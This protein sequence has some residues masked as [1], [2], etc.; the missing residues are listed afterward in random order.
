M[1]ISTAVSDASQSACRGRSDA[2]GPFPEKLHRMLEY[3]DEEGLCDVVSW[4][5]DGRA[6]KIHD[7]DA[8]M[9][10]VAGHFFRATK[11]RSVHRQFLL[12]GF[13]R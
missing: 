7:A 3:A 2:T 10:R 9:S 5:L 1:P 4:L 6:F 13:T 11:L 8:F 12:W